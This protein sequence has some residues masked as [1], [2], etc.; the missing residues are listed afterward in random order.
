LLRGSKK[1]QEGGEHSGSSSSGLAGICRLQQAQT[2][3]ASLNIHPVI[4]PAPD[5]SRPG[6]RMTLL[7]TLSVSAL[8]VSA[9]KDRPSFL[10]VAVIEGLHALLPGFE[11]TLRG[12]A[13]CLLT[14][15]SLRYTAC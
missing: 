6:R 8:S 7:F 10:V 12:E 13:N 2:D 1:L 3:M 15:W 11:L 4:E 9:S 5:G 14:L